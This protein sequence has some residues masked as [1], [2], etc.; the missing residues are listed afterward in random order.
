MHLKYA[1]LT[2]FRIFF[3]TKFFIGNLSLCCG[4]LW[5]FLFLSVEPVL[6]LLFYNSRNMDFSFSYILIILAVSPG[7]SAS[8]LLS[9]ITM[10]KAT[11][12]N[13]LAKSSRCFADLSVT[14]CLLRTS[15]ATLSQASLWILSGWLLSATSVVEVQVEDQFDCVL[16]LPSFLSIG[17]P[18]RRGNFWISPVFFIFITV[19]L[20]LGYYTGFQISFSVS[21]LTP[22]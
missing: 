3:K 6:G 4:G 2:L 22:L 18:E 19:I 9:H 16:H 14:W 15:L 7:F 21:G 5:W 10:Q 12:H 20:S 1:F 8:C 17:T 13:V 11:Y